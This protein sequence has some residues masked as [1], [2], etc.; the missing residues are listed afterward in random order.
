MSIY[1]CLFLVLSVACG[2]FNMLASVPDT[3]ALLVEGST[4]LF[5]MLF[6]LSLLIGRRIKFDP[7]LR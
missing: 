2:A 1:G 6:V 3:W 4:V 5:G 7:V